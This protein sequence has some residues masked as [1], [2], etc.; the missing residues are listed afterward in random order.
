M[1]TPRSGRGR[2]RKTASKR[3]APSTNPKVKVKGHTRSPRGPD[4][5]KKP[6]R[7]RGHRRRFG[8]RR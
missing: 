1:Q 4:A 5:G 2:K 3:S 6:V 8:S 7:V